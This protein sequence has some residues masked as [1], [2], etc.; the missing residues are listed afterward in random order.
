[1]TYTGKALVTT[2]VG[3]PAGLPLMRL[4]LKAF[5]M[6][7]GYKFNDNMNKYFDQTLTDPATTA[8]DE[9]QFKVYLP[10]TDNVPANEPP[11]QPAEQAAPAAAAQ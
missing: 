3:S 7:R 1:T 10:I 2:W 9:Q 4:A 8:Q 6:S 11:P 5:A